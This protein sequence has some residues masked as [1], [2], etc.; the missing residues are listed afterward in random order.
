[1]KLEFKSCDLGDFFYKTKQNKKLSYFLLYLYIKVDYREKS[2]NR[3]SWLEEEEEENAAW[4][5]GN[6]SLSEVKGVQV[7]GA[8]N[9]VP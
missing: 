9:C 2:Q 8:P 6:V 5:T 4:S 3:D 1:M 7:D